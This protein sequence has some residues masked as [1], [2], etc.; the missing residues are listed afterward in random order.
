MLTAPTL[1]AAIPF[2][3]IDPVAF[4]VGPIAVHWYGMAYVAGILIGWYYARRMV[5]T[6]SIWP[7]GQPPMTKT[8]LD[9]F[10][11]WVALGIVLG[12]R[13]GYILFYDFPAVAAN[14]LR[15]IEI[16]NGGMSFHG[17]LVGTTIAMILFARRN[18][19]IAWSLFDIVAAVC[20]I[21]LFFG[22]IAN[23]INGE[24]WG[25]ISDVPWAI[26]FPTGGPFTRHPSQL[27]EAG[28]EG[29]ALFL[30][31]RLLTHHFNALKSPGLVT[32][33]FIS[34]YAV[35]RIFVEFFREPDAQIGYLA[36]NWLT[37]GMVLSLPMLAIGIWAMARA[38]RSAQLRE[39]QD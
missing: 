2:P 3:A 19:I 28:L 35:S 30:L 26:A 21:G 7:N 9:D 20:P 23:F 4:S 10:L 22:R 5:S 6:P 36:G 25:R 27:Y 11:V 8:H 33:A 34:F 24:L 16:W 17:G 37:M 38:R 31:L 15:A 14:P 32:G 29:V 12:G 18:G 13:I 39:V 1:L